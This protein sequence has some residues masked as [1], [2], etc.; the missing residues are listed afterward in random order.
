MITGA[1]GYANPIIADG[2]EPINI[3]DALLEMKIFDYNEGKD[4]NGNL[5]TENY[6]IS[7]ANKGIVNINSKNI[8]IVTKNVT[9]FHPEIKRNFSYG[10]QAVGNGIINL[11]NSSTQQIDI[12]TTSDYFGIGVNADKLN[13]TG[14]K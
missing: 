4:T 6:A 12:I 5:V 1:V 14:G 3:N 10:V 13:E 2:G 7:S 11:G 8:K 9:E